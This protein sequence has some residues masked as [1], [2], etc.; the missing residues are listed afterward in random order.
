[1]SK[2]SKQKAGKPVQHKAADYEGVIS[3]VVELLDAAYRPDAN[4]RNGVAEIF[5]R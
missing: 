5:R 3:S 2:P 1:M 4:F